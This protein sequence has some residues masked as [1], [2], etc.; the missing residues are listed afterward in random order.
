MKKLFWIFLLS[1]TALATP[2]T[3]FSGK[4]MIEAPSRGT[5]RPPPTILTLNQIGNEVTGS[6]SVRNFAASASPTHTEVLDGKVEGDTL[7]F[8][9][10]SGLDRPVKVFYK[11]TLAG[12]EIKFTVTGGADLSAFA[13]P[14]ASPQPATRQIIAKRTK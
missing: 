9:M 14:N 11:G 10:W 4:W 8:Y 6:V 5:M 1:L 2:G 3:N 12:E 13:G 7:S